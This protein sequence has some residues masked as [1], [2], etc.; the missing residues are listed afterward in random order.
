M[1]EN[2]LRKGKDIKKKIKKKSGDRYL[3]WEVVGP[4]GQVVATTEGGVLL[5][6]VHLQVLE[7]V[8]VL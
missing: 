6:H 2:Q 7:K 5:P 4:V 3:E 1:E 8:V